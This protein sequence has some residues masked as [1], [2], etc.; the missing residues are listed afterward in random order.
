MR[1]A[2]AEAL[3]FIPYR[4]S[5]YDQYRCHGDNKHPRRRILC[6]WESGHWL[7]A[8]WEVCSCSRPWHRRIRPPR[9]S[10]PPA[11]TTVSRAVHPSM[12]C[13]NA[14]PRLSVLAGQAGQGLSRAGTRGEQANQPEI[15]KKR[16][17]QS[18][19]AWQDYVDMMAEYRMEVSGGSE[20]CSNRGISALRPSGP[21]S[22]SLSDRGT[23]TGGLHA[24][25][26]PFHA[27][28]SCLR[29]VWR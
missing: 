25:F 22:V 18:Q 12:K 1:R 6:N 23:A 21:R 9:K 27:L 15:C 13:V 24:P 2:G 7:F 17:D 29:A 4:R 19:T 26:H 16:L 8:C 3:C 10:W 20:G 5:M 14:T 28:P 11:S